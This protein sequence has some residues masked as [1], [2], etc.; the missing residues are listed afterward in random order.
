MD[1]TIFYVPSSSFMKNYA[2]KLF[3]NCSINF[4]MLMSKFEHS[5]HCTRHVHLSLRIGKTI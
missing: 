1:E 5:T 3:Q 2:N 4:S